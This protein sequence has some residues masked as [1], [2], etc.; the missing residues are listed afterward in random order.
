MGVERCFLAAGIG[1]VIGHIVLGLGAGIQWRAAVFGAA[2]DGF[3]LLQRRAV[4]AF[5]KVADDAHH[6]VAATH[7]PGGLWCAVLHPDDAVHQP[8]IARIRVG[9]AI[10]KAE[11]I[12]RTFSGLARRCGNGRHAA[13]LFP[14]QA[15][16]IGQVF[17]N[18]AQRVDV[19]VGRVGAEL[20]RHVPMAQ[21]GQQG[22]VG[23]LLHGRE[24]AW[25]ERLQAVARF[26][27]AGANGHGDGERIGLHHRAENARASGWQL[28]IQHRLRAA[29]GEKAYALGQGFEQALQIGRIVGQH[30]K[31]G[32]HASQRPRRDDTGLVQPL[33]RHTLL[34]VAGVRRIRYLGVAAC[35]CGSGSSAHLCLCRA[36]HAGQH[37][38]AH[39]AGRI[40]QPTA[41]SGLLRLA[42]R[43]A[44]GPVSAQGLRIVSV[45]E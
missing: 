4:P 8:A 36:S 28:G 5:N 11:K 15:E 29:L 31:T 38:G 34:G 2:H 33:E 45:T 26:K 23:V 21:R 1:A 24:L 42:G 41:A 6:L 30:I 32:H 10:A 27:Q 22:I 35:R 19:G 3:L 12:A 9:R 7:G 14:A 18:V 39:D 13:L 16:Q 17:D 37:A 20:D 40:A 43:L 25:L 44:C